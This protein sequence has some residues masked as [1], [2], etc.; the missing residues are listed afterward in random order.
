ML[1]EEFF[2]QGDLEKQIDLPI[3]MLCD[4]STTNV[5]GAQPGFI[6]FVTMPFFK[7]LGQVL[8]GILDKGQSVDGLKENCEKWKAYEETEED[9]KMYK[10]QNSFMKG[11]I[12]HMPNFHYREEMSD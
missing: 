6:N 8:P 5:A 9:K 11:S 3:S 4:R 10:E 2:A 12:T 1:F 7:A